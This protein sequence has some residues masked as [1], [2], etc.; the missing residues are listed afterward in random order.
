LTAVLL[1]GMLALVAAGGLLLL[2]SPPAASEVDRGMF[3]N[4]PAVMP[5][6]GNWRGLAALLLG[7]TAVVWDQWR[8][9]RQAAAGAVFAGL[10]LLCGLLA[11]NVVDR[12]SRLDWLAFHVLQV[13]WTATAALAAGATWAADR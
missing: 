6:L 10:L 8:H 13:G 1:P 9:N 7:V 12:S 5:L 3:W 2:P 11:A 4:W